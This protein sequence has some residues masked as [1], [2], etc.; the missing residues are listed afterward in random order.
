MGKKSSDQFRALATTIFLIVIWLLLP[1]AIRSIL[2][3]S[4]Y[5][6]QAPSWHVISWVDDLQSYWPQ[7][8]HSKNQLIE[9]GR[10]L[11][12]RNAAY[13]LLRQ[14]HEALKT[15]L[16]AL[17]GALNLPSLPQY[18]Y[19]IA[20]VARRELNAW[21]QHIIIRKGNNYG[22]PLGAA[23]V[24][25][26]GVVGRVTEVHYST[27]VIELISSPAFRMAATFDGDTRPVTYQ[28]KHNTSLSYAWGEVRDVPPD[29]R[30][31]SDRPLRLI[32]SRLGGVFPQG[33]Y[34][35]GVVSLEPDSNG[36][37]SR[38]IVKL[39]PNIRDIHEV[40]VLIPMSATTGG[41][42]HARRY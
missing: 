31:S 1:V 33:L 40:A 18:K 15:E 21:W 30:T 35:G 11:S 8:V 20:R 23:V 12:R 13:Q 29:I 24:F 36:L 9:A 34:I 32:S 22:I 16:A 7:R 10:D 28:G 26:D 19:E 2:R 14:E 17:Q 27:S 3:V 5:E 38:G 37:F 6:F 4:F 25:R 41:K 42:R 39:S